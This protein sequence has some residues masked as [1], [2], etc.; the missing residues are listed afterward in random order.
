MVNVSGKTSNGCTYEGD[1]RPASAGRVNWS[2]TF[3]HNG[4]Y[5]GMRHGCVHDMLGVDPI[6]IDDAVKVDIESTWT[7][8][9]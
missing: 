4:D 6:G 9:T 7:Q 8:A 2:A 3:R 1:Y 5:A